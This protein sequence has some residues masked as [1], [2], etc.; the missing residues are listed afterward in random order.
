MRSVCGSEASSF[1]RP[2]TFHVGWRPKET[3]APEPWLVLLSVLGL[4]GNRPLNDINFP[5][6]H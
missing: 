4:P 1:R 6:E 2:T 3:P 5:S